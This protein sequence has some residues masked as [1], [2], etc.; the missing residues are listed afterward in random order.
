MTPRDDLSQF[1]E[2][3]RR[4]EA[5][6][7][8][9]PVKPPIDPRR[10]RRRRL[11]GTIVAVVVIV[12]LLGSAASYAAITLNS[13]LGAAAAATTRPQVAP[14]AAA[15]LAVPP[16]GESAISV[17]GADD[18][19]G[20]GASGI[21]SSGGDDKALPIASISK[22]ITA[23]VI[24]D[25]KPLGT[26]GNGPTITFSKDD[27][28]LYDKYYVLGATIAAMPTGSSMSEH[29]AIETMLVVSACNYAEAVSTWAFGSQAAFLAA[30]KKWLTA[31]GML[32]TR[33]VEPTGLDP[34]NV[35]TPSDLITLGK[36]AIADP[37]IAAIVAKPA[38]DIPT[39]PPTL[40]TNQLLGVDGVNGIKT[41]TLGDSSNLLYSATLSVGTPQPLRVVG[42][43]LNGY[44][45]DSVDADV[46]VLLDS[47]KAGFHTVSVGTAGQVVGTY[48][49]PWGA[50]AQMVLASSA[51][52]FTWSNTAITSTMSTT[53]L[54]TG[55]DGSPVG[56]VS[57][58]AGKS[59]VTVPV[60]L[61]G[62]IRPPTA[63]WRLTHPAVTFKLH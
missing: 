48:S 33:I 58:T 10:R 38:L 46:R 12:L 32:N 2:M 27:N 56:S 37:V 1:T 44:S 31:H 54:T 49:T 41:G 5:H 34:R 59:T 40:N 47:L 3:L 62:S 14:P 6:D 26:S 17:S 50:K 53:T 24:L 20:S 21:L 8:R 4:A 7:A 60:L 23:L 57:W 25:H 36:L 52:V 22:L 16:E 9:G 18:Y 13:P 61:Q 39:L 28:A 55:R 45:R 11:G 15:V 35:S 63:W 19:L 29:D 42:V 30:T 43:V 51:S